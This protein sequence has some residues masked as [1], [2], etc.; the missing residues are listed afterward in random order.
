MKFTLLLYGNTSQAQHYTPDEAI[1]ARQSWL[2]LPEEMKAAQ[3]YLFNYGLAPVTDA[4]TVRVR[5]GKT[6]VTAGPV[7]EMAEHVDGYF[8]LDCINLEKAIG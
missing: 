5:A 4:T 6:V 8:L 1:A 2:D 7:T 3:M